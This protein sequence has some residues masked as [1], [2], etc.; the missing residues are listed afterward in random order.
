M[1]GNQMKKILIGTLFA[2]LIVA[3]FA[4][5]T[6]LTAQSINKS[7]DAIKAKI[8]KI[9]NI[10]MKIER[11]EVPPLGIQEAKVKSAKHQPR[12]KKMNQPKRQQKLHRTELN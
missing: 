3:C 4:L 8:E 7:Q 5:T 6:K 2:G 10:S 9:P 11:S 1:K 12:G